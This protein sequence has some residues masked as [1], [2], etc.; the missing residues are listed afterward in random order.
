M[1]SLE[2]FDPKKRAPPYLDS[3]RSLE[4]CRRSGIDP[5]E[6]LQRP[7]GYFR[8]LLGKHTP[9]AIVRMHKDHYEQRRLEKL[10]L[11][12]DARLAV[13]NE[14]SML[15]PALSSQTVDKNNF[16]I[17]HEQRKLALMQKKQELEMQQMLEHERVLEDIRRRNED[18]EEKAKMREDLRLVE[19]E[20][21]RREAEDRRLREEERKRELEAAREQEIRDLQQEKFLQ[22]QRKLQEDE[23]KAKER[24]RAARQREMELQEKQEQLRLQTEMIMN[25][26]RAAVEARR[27]EMEARDA[28]RLEMLE[29]RKKMMQK[30][31]AETRRAKMERLETAKANLQAVLSDQRRRFQ[32]KQRLSEERRQYFEFQRYQQKVQSARRSEAKQKSIARTLAQSRKIELRRK[33]EYLASMARA[34]Q[35]RQELAL[36]AEYEKAT[37][38]RQEE[39]REQQRQEVKRRMEVIEAER[40]AEVFMRLQQS[41][42]QV[43]DVRARQ[44]WEHRVNQERMALQRQDREEEVRRVMRVQEYQREKTLHRIKSDDAKAAKVFQEKQALMEMRLALRRQIEARKQQLLQQFEEAKKTAAAKKSQ[45]GSSRGFYH[46][47]ETTAP[48]SRV[49][50]ARRPA[51][52]RPQKTKTIQSEPDTIVPVSARQSVRTSIDKHDIE[53]EVRALQQKKAHILMEELE[54][55]QDKEEDREELLQGTSNLKEKARLEKIFSL[56]REQAGERLK[57][58]AQKFEESIWILLRLDD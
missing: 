23:R 10:K 38:Q 21:A 24:K 19:V 6:L 51:S 28:A 26:Q 32:E 46:T 45:A 13:M 41:E 53:R 18:K 25:E 30:R 4:A 42:A 2:N 22:E 8:R 35:R 52:A 12:V 58:L 49:G 31:S 15:G 33:R 48:T 16:L 36:L 3:P 50:S 14:E 1:I 17:Q 47:S 9:K 55:E 43:A 11:V 40:K 5:E 27:R 39:E 54:L 57:A 44:A 29:R 34:E 37:K 20:A 7:K 56:E